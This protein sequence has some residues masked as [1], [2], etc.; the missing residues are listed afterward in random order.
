MNLCEIKK[1]YYFCSRN[2]AEQLFNKAVIYS[3]NRSNSIPNIFQDISQ[4]T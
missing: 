4:I 1:M 3:K 2:I